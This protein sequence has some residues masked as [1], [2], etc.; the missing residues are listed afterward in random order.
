MN[1]ESVTQKQSDLVHDLIND[2]MHE[3]SREDIDPD[4]AAYMLVSA[5]V[6]LAHA[7]HRHD[8]VMVTQLIAAS[9]MMANGRVS[10]GDN[11]DEEEEEVDERF[12]AMDMGVRH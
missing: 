2:L 10:A 11:E 1:E 3:F 6:T 4:F 8:P 7:N 12:E 9:M 5:G